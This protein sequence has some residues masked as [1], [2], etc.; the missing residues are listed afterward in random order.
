MAPIR[1]TQNIPNNSI[2]IEE[3]VKKGIQTQDSPTEPI[4]HK[5]KVMSCLKTENLMPYREG[6]KIV[7]YNNYKVI[8][9]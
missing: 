7:G 8:R 2:I 1:I 3:T 4:I 9:I 5:K 6:K